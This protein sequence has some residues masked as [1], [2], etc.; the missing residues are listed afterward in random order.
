M[1]RLALI[2][3]DMRGGGAEQVALRQMQHFV[4]RGFDVD[5]LLMRAEGELLDLVP[6]SVRIID[7]QASR[8]RHLV[9]P[10]VHYLKTEQ[11]HALQA[12][13]W[14]LTI[15]AVIARRLAKSRARL[16]LADHSTLSHQY[17]T[18]LPQRLLLRASVRMFYPEADA[19]VAVSK[20]AAIDLAKLTG[21][22]SDSIQVIYNP[23]SRPPGSSEEAEKL[24]AVWGV[25]SGQRVLTVGKLK[26]E[27]EHPL[28]VRAFSR[29]AR[30]SD[31]RLVILGS[32]PMQ[33]EIERL[34]EK[35][36]LTG[37]VILPGFIK[38]PWPW[39]QSAD[40]F[41]LSSRFEGYPLVLV[42]AM[43]CGL[44][45]VSTDCES[46][47]REILEHGRFGALVPVG[48]EAA[49]AAAMEVALATP[50]NREV[51]KERAETLFKAG[52]PEQYLKLM[53]GSALPVAGGTLPAA[54]PKIVHVIDSLARGGTETFL[55]NLLP[56]L[57]ERYEIVLVTLKPECDFTPE[58]LR[59]VQVHC[60]HYTTARSIPRCARAL[61]K[62]VQSHRPQLVRAQLY[63]SGV[64][65]RMAVP[66][67]VPV[68]FSI[69]S[70][71][72]DDGYRANRLAAPVE[73]LTYRKRHH[74][75]SVT[76]D[77][78]KDFDDWIGIKGPA[79]ILYNFISP[80][81][82]ASS[83]VRTG[84]GKELRLVSVGML[85]EVKNY[86]YLIEALRLLKGE[87]PISLDIYG[88]GHLRGRLERL[89]QEAGVNVT[90]KGKRPDIHSVL[91][92]YDLLV[93]PSI[94]EGFANAAVEAMAAG[95][96][97]LVSDQP[98]FREITHGNALF[99]DP[100]DPISLAGLIRS[101]RAGSVDLPRLSEEGI[102]LTREHYGAETYL[103]KLFAI[104]DR[105]MAKSRSGKPGTRG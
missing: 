42:E 17:S 81:F 45:I 101:V 34:V 103:A 9:R 40:L 62:M 15:T 92:D 18:L 12:L 72:S 49:L 37:K 8:V 70:R 2:L 53:L 69:H 44:P 105:A 102:A 77:A 39:Y 66:R 96:P 31:A 1:K 20:G 85:K 30:S 23:M 41:V 3:P 26:D 14:P 97:V 24:D 73:R 56:S 13:M 5:L 27:K 86:E 16:I 74:L 65:T 90:L 88:E 29:M 32:G 87:G 78:L 57:L 64:V 89:I 71:M 51:I 61:R 79:D 82:H 98:S 38:D 52:D 7:L 10:L 84:I 104:Y 91:G 55:I 63:L 33:P 76:A 99:F 47:P 75:I 46:G 4:A 21:I 60:L 83:R 93:M 68:V 19:R 50:A 43:L 25:P 94:Y 11:P 95:L 6:P 100:R 35:E 80:A 36:A 22:A 59:G 58:Q 67:D 48:D 54:K 28:L